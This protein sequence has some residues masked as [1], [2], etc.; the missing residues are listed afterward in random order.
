ITVKWTA[1]ETPSRFIN[2]R[3]FVTLECQDT[4]T[5]SS[6][7][8]GWVR[9]IHSV[10]LPDVPD[11]YDSYGLVRGKLGHTGYVFIESDRPG[12]L[13]VIHM[14]QVDLQG[15]A[16]V[17]HSLF[18]RAMKTRVAAIVKVNKRLR[19]LRLSQER[20]VDDCDLVPARDRVRCV[21]C[22]AKFGLLVRKHH[23]RRCGEVVC[24]KCCSQWTI[25]RG[26]ADA[27]VRVC[28]TCCVESDNRANHV[29]VVEPT[30]SRRVRS[31]RKGNT[32]SCVTDVDEDNEFAF[33]DDEE[34]PTVRSDDDMLPK[35]QCLTNSRPLPLPNG[36]FHL[37]TLAPDHETYYKRRARDQTMSLIRLAH[38]RND[39]YGPV[40]WK[41]AGT[42]KGVQMYEG[43]PK[44]STT[45]RVNYVCGVASV[46]ASLEEIAAYFDL[47]TT[48]KAKR[49][50]RE[51][52][53]DM[54]DGHVLHSV[55]P[56][57]PTNPMHQITIKWTAI[58]TPSP[59]INNRDFVTLECHD[60]FTYAN[61]K[62]G[63]VRSVHSI[64]LPGVP[65][66]YDA[67]G[68]VRGKLDCSGFVFVESDKPRYL[69]VIHICQVDLQGNIVLPHSLF[70]LAMKTRIAAVVKINKRLRELRLSQEHLVDECDLVPPHNRTRCAV[71][72][73]KFGLMARKHHCRRCGEVVCS[74][75]SAKWTIRRDHGHAQVRICV[76]C[77]IATDNR[78]R[79]TVS[80]LSRSEPARSFSNRL[81]SSC[82]SEDYDNSDNNDE[83]DDMFTVRSTDNI[84][85]SLR[86]TPE[87]RCCA[88]VAAFRRQVALRQIS[89]LL[90]VEPMDI[91]TPRA[92]QQPAPWATAIAEGADY[93]DG[94]WIEKERDGSPGARLTSDFDGPPGFFRLRKLSRSEHSFLKHQACE[95]A[96]TLVQLAHM[97][98]DDFGPVQWTPAGTC[99]G[100]QMSNVRMNYVCGVAS[101][102]ATLEEVVA[103][104]D[105]STTAKTKRFAREYNDDML[106]GCVLHT[107]VS[108]TVTNPM[109][110]ITVKWTAMETPSPF[111]HDRDFVTLECQDT[112]TDS[113]GK[114]GWVR[115]I[116]SI[117]LPDVPDLYNDYGLVRGKLYRTGY[118]FIESDNPGYLEVIHM[119]QV[120]LKGSL[121]LP[122]SLFL[123]AMKT[124]I[125]AV[126]KLNKRLRE[127]RLSQEHLVDECDLVPARDRAHCFVC[128][129][130]F[131]MLARKR[132]CRRC[133]EV[134]CSKCCS[135]WTIKRDHGHAQVRICVTCC[136][137]S[138]NRAQHLEVVEPTI[139]TSASILSDVNA[140]RCISEVDEEED[141][142]DDDDEENMYTLR[143]VDHSAKPVKSGKGS[144]RST[145]RGPVV[146]SRRPVFRCRDSPTWSTKT[147]IVTSTR[148]ST[149]QSPRWSS[150][151]AANCSVK[152]RSG[153]I[154]HSKARTT[155]RVDSRRSTRASS[156]KWRTADRSFG[157]LST[158]NTESLM[159]QVS[160]GSSADS[161]LQPLYSSSSESENMLEL[162]LGDSP[163]SSP[164]HRSRP[165]D[166]SS[167]S[168]RHSTYEMQQQLADLSNQQ[169]ALETDLK[170]NMLEKARVAQEIKELQWALELLQD[171]A[172]TEC[173]GR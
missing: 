99:K 127:L 144:T 101:V 75:C 100:V 35:A 167:V 69:E 55:V 165:G 49:F 115:S 162:M 7:K 57:T 59:F 130:K 125:A 31:F 140:V 21:V 170:T 134:V 47:S 169:R 109:H 66:L 68:L 56:P 20:L 29:N 123:R 158:G 128:A 97:R 81:T 138:D 110:Q 118:V 2:N 25:K 159:Y 24:S 136:V 94:N 65:E 152:H 28:V 84:S 150:T 9:S 131:G 166:A 4:F 15:S 160:L 6:G 18:R 147:K 141:D 1:M 96:A 87:N 46:V 85:R 54:L 168:V 113:T 122:H 58:E 89:S 121:V 133:G 13:E 142:D 157:P 30:R 173:P 171:A 14:Y 10:S 107:L 91:T 3:D 103:Y 163:P 61:G 82:I 153:G 42:C 62:R 92:A 120:D 45:T 16:V 143:S 95:Q 102:V 79:H 151:S 108:P 93:S 71:C 114:R 154:D 145:R 51:Y 76:T 67:Y 63:W 86:D 72:V 137:V 146:L 111:I 80:E 116:H 50:A 77:G 117:N 139:S 26:D 126:V 27:K 112:F 104:F 36:Y 119:C 70:R 12:Y 148:H 17:P 124:R 64:D 74:K 155:S 78:C 33:H 19:E 41:S 83:N 38:M 5:D 53:D 43:V 88:P 8:R 22:S 52:T 11:L 23:C 129:V 149:R 105:L 161:S 37:D 40:R 132:N 172:K 135:K 39:D 164:I 106:D 32:T 90:P 60:T 156:P 48:A 44:D 34:M 73:V 98:D